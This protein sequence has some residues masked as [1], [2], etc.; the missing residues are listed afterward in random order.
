MKLI[1]KKMV[2]EAKTSHGV[3]VRAFYYQDVK[4]SA[5]EYVEKIKVN[6][7][8]MEAVSELDPI[9]VKV[10]IQSLKDSLVVFENTFGDFNK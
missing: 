8:L 7:E 2:H 3:D 9:K 4:E 10:A 6:I 5:A 1:N